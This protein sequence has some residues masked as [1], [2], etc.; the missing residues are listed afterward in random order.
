MS[1][2][3]KETDKE[4]V[5][6]PHGD[7]A[8]LMDSVSLIEQASQSPSPSSESLG[9]GA[10]GVGA[11]PTAYHSSPFDT[12]PP[13]EPT[14]RHSS[15]SYSRTSLSNSDSQLN[16]ARAQSQHASPK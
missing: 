11:I 12:P 8:A 16:R 5:Y 9:S 15:R 3:E 7:K 10:P 1:T 6:S 4:I 2:R 14:S 13:S